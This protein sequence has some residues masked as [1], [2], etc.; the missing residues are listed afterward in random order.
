MKLGIFTDSHYS[1]W[2]RYDRPYSGVL[3]KIKKALA[4]FEKENC[5]Y[6]IC[7][8]DL[9][10]KE[11]TKEEELATFQKVVA[12]F[13]V[14]KVPMFVLVGNHDTLDFEKQTFYQI[15]GENRKPKTM[16]VGEKELLFLDTCFFADGREFT[17]ESGWDRGKLQDLD[18]FKNALK[19]S[20][21]KEIYVFTHFCIDPAIDEGHRAVNANKIMQAME[22]D[23][24]VKAVFQG[25]HH[26]NITSNVNGI[27]YFAYADMLT[28]DDAFFVAE[29]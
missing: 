27:S 2:D 13:D 3:E 12:A 6:I 24:R 28:K 22:N 1:T 25:H 16:R 20:T 26:K 17:P 14:C 4:H 9:I 11:K 19:E 23:G 21:A 15:L 7:L 10:D 8:G 18:G 5:D 29:I